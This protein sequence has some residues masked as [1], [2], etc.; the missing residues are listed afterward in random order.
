MDE[1]GRRAFRQLVA[2]GRIL[3]FISEIVDELH[4]P[5]WEELVHRRAWIEWRDS[6][7]RYFVGSILAPYLGAHWPVDPSCFPRNW[8]DEQ[9]VE[10]VRRLT[11]K[12]RPSSAVYRELAHRGL[13]PAQ[14]VSNTSPTTMG[15]ELAP[16]NI[17]EYDPEVILGQ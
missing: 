11:I 17:I 7:S 4:A 16:A 12:H 3:E 14:F 10:V 13:D 6:P 2:E 5:D 9:L 8:D 1:V 15:V